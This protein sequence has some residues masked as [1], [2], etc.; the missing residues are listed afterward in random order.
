MAFSPFPPSSSGCLFLS[1]RL[2]FRSPVFSLPPLPFC[3]FS[4]FCLSLLFAMFSLASRSSDL[5]LRSAGLLFF[6]L[7]FFLPFG[8]FL[9][10]FLLALLFFSSALRSLAVPSSAARLSSF[11]PLFRRGLSLLYFASLF[12]SS[13]PL[14]PIAG[15]HPFLVG[16][17]SFDS[18]RVLSPLL[19]RMLFAFCGHF[20]FHL[21]FFPVVCL[22]PSPLLPHCVSSCSVLSFFF[23]PAFM[24]ASCS[25]GFFSSFSF[26]DVCSDR[27]LT[28]R[29]KS[30]C[31]PAKGGTGC[32]RFNYQPDS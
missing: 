13:P 5:L 23:F 29:I 12:R 18:L 22:L 1:C 32:Y 16:S 6:R 2:F 27:I 21:V 10:S 15:I 25:C 26:L 14:L 4:V 31:S 9:R 30:I 8:C 28:C 24:V 19:F 7:F 17:V 3:F 11:P 20:L